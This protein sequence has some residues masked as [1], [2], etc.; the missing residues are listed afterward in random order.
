MLS[1]PLP[2]Q[3][4][5][6]RFPPHHHNPQIHQPACLHIENLESM[7]LHFRS[8]II[9][10]FPFGSLIKVSSHNTICR[11]EKGGIRKEGEFDWQIVHW[12]W[13]LRFWLIIVSIT[14]GL[15]DIKKGDGMGGGQKNKYRIW[16]NMFWHYW[17]RLV[18]FIWVCLLLQIIGINVFLKK[19]RLYIEN[20]IYWQGGIYLWRVLWI[21]EKGE[22]KRI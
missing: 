19:G 16:H 18:W 3:L 13:I 1:S 11:I 2:R 10:L 22:K 20:H 7:N 21:K 15:E 12:F 4:I 9:T 14:R 6:S 5:T 17:V 8:R